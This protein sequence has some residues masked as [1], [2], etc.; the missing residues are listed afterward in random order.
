MERQKW[1]DNLVI[2][3]EIGY[4]S[5][6]MVYLA[7]DGRKKYALKISHILSDESKYN[8][9]KSIWREY[10]FYK[11]VANKYPKYFLP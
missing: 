1:I 4:G 7:T 10:D 11:K 9:R 6:G 8:L 3:K 2:K 5:M